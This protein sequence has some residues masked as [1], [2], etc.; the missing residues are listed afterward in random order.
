MIRTSH[1]RRQ[2]RGA[3]LVEFALCVPILLTVMF[4]IVEFSRVLQVQQAVRQAA[5]EGARAGLTLDAATSDVT[6]ASTS[7]LALVGV[8]NGTITSTPNPLTYT[9]ST[10]SVTV[11]AVGQT[12]GWFAKFFT[13]GKTLTSTITLNRE[14]QAVSNP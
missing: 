2:R 9:S 14:V 10:I 5:F 3:V 11:S 4:A 8:K 12:N 1:Q 7:A 6:N 13:G